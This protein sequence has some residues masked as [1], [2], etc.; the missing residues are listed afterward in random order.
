MPNRQQNSRLN[1]VVYTPDSVAEEVT[2]VGLSAVSV[3]ASRILEPSAG[4][5]A[6][7]RALATCGIEE[8]KITAVDVDSVATQALQENFADLTIVEADFLEYS[9]RPDIGRFDLILGN[10]PFI[11][12]VAYTATFETNLSALAQE[13][14]FPRSL[15]KN[16]W[17]A[18]VVAAAKLVNVGGVLALVVPYEMITVKYGREVQL[19][20]INEGFSVQIYV[21]DVKAFPQIEQDA[22]ILLAINKGNTSAEL[23]ISRIEE[24]TKLKPTRTAQVDIHDD[25]TAAIDVKSVL[26][27]ADT[28]V[29]MHKLR[30]GSM[31]H[32]K[33]L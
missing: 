27:D 2:K 17:A 20:L 22:V 15:L 6:F 3:K 19:F 29:L 25:K 11:K 13:V 21:P 16:A 8:P 33:L 7:L 14:A 10:P 26:L 30:K 9:L 1:G 5:G 31:L 18:F 32:G 24:C 4:D 28:V 23:K 12:R